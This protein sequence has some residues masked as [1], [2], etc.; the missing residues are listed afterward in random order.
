MFE[1]GSCGQRRSLSVT[2]RSLAFKQREAWCSQ[3]ETTCWYLATTFSGGAGWLDGDSACEA[4]PGRIQYFRELGVQVE[5]AAGER[6]LIREAG[7]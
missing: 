7:K 5:A 2:L 1:Q 3:A 6:R 4:F